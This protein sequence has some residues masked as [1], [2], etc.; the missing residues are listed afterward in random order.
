MM[1]PACGVKMKGEAASP[2]LPTPPVE[3]PPA[4]PPKASALAS[5]GIQIAA[6]PPPPARAENGDRCSSAPGALIV[7]AVAADRRWSHRCR[8]RAAAAAI[9]WLNQ[10]PPTAI[11]V[12]GPRI[13][14]ALSAYRSAYRNRDLEGVA[15]V[16]SG[17][18]GGHKRTMEQAFTNCLVYE[19]TFADMHVALDAADPNSA[20]VDVRSTYNCT[21]T[22]GGRQT[23]TSH[24]EVFALKKI[25][26]EW[27]IASAAPVSA[28]R[29]A[30][31][32]AAGRRVRV[33]ME[34]GKLVL[35]RLYNSMTDGSNCAPLSA[36]R[37][38]VASSAGSAAR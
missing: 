9:P 27:R 29:P 34:R 17:A 25:G 26:D 8:D 13:E 18:A 16:V 21:P 6:S 32:R 11:E 20:E 12:E 2:P 4:P 22:S 37:R 3:R 30:V 10:P 1:P 7:E 31:A 24:H 38:R 33:C 35:H 28:G 23:E 36:R 15:K 5:A 19:V 14:A